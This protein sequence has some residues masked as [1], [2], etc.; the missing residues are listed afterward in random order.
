MP[1]RK[2]RLP[3]DPPKRKMGFWQKFVL[4]VS[5]LASIAWLVNFTT[6]VVQPFILEATHQ[7]KEW[8]AAFA[9]LGQLQNQVTQL[10]EQ[11]AQLEEKVNQY[12]PQPPLPPD[13]D[14]PSEASPFASIIKIAVGAALL[15]LALMA[16]NQG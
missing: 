13:T 11:V 12:H 3:E 1:R 4:I 8:A 6:G 15:I 10:Q 5:I 16:L 7:V 2:G 9:L 14:G